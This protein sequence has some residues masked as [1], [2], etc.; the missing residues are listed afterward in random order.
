MNFLHWYLTKYLKRGKSE[1][2]FTLIEILLAVMLSSVVLLGI[3][4][5]LVFVLNSNQKA[6]AKTLQRTQLNR[7]L[8][9]ITEDIK[10]AR[11]ISVDTNGTP[12]DLSDD[13]LVLEYYPDITNDTPVKIVEYYLED[14]ENPWLGPKVMKRYE[15]IQRDINGDGDMTDTVDDV[16]EAVI[17]EDLNN[18]GDMVD[19]G[20]DDVEETTTKE[21]TLVD[22]ITENVL[23]DPFGCTG[24]GESLFNQFGFQ[25]CITQGVAE[26]GVDIYKVA[27]SLSGELTDNAGDQADSEVLNVT[28]KIFARS[29]DPS[30]FGIQAP[31][32]TSVLNYDTQVVT[33]TW[34]DATQGVEPYSYF[35]YRCND[36]IGCT[37][38]PPDPDGT[39]DPD[40][41]EI[42]FNISTNSL[43]DNVSSI[44][45]GETICYVVKVIDNDDYNDVSSRSCVTKTPLLVAPS[46]SSFTKSGTDITVLW[47]PATGGNPAYTYKIYH[48]QDTNICP[49]T[50]F[51]AEGVTGIDYLHEGINTDPNIR[52]CYKVEV[53][54][55]NNTT[56]SSN[57]RCTGGVLSPPIISSI[58]QTNLTAP[59]ITWDTATGGTEPYNYTI[60][61][62]DTT[63]TGTCTTYS[64][65]DTE[66]ATT[67][68][69]NI[70]SILNGQKVCY[71][72]NVSDSASPNATAPSTEDCFIKGSPLVAPGVNISTETSGVVTLTWSAA[73]GGSSPYTYTIERCDTFSSCTVFSSQG[74]T[75]NLTVT[76]N[77]SSIAGGRE[78][79]YRIKVTDSVGTEETG[80]ENHF[81]KSSTLDTPTISI[82]GANAVQPNLTWA[83]ISNAT[84][85]DVYRC[86]GSNCDPTTGTLAQSPTTNSY[87]ESTNPT[88][89]GDQWCYAVKAK[90]TSLN[91]VSG[92]SN[93]VCGLTNG[94]IAPTITSIDFSKK[95]VAGD[96][97]TP[98]PSTSSFDA[99]VNWQSIVGTTSYKLFYCLGNGCTPN[100]NEITPNAVNSNQTHYDV[101]GTKDIY[102]CYG[103]KTVKDGNISNLSNVV[104]VQSDHEWP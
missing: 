85:Y 42:A 97:F 17:K 73:T 26:S 5:A 29:V 55:Q 53:S 84:A 104:C 6:E 24:T 28:S 51:I 47:N 74:T 14:K 88:N 93:Q 80:S 18:D 9:Y 76:N 95:N 94:V 43:T 16:D 81:T 99:V 27:L 38:I 101:T 21:Q 57:D 78:I 66:T 58:D 62:C 98:S 70:T 30:G 31:A 75:S 59:V 15:L 37:P 87:D 96:A 2:G 72:I 40:T 10:T 65:I 61:R 68:T 4:T 69:D 39:A 82:D 20:I 19:T 91:L 48:C 100:T 92:F 79:Y 44:P 56:A 50:A 1:Q 25:A 63:P 60:T 3:G 8:E 86:S 33:V 46:I 36:N 32:V 89:T 83:T 77:V 103:V 34:T 7:A 52:H 54:D 23:V 102:Y 41:T 71:K 45:D 13:K 35:V 11:V 90:N 64:D 67:F 22:G 12:S 49:P